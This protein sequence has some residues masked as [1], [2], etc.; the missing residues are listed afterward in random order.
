[1]FLF[2]NTYDDLG[3]KSI[4]LYAFEYNSAFTR[5]SNYPARLDRCRCARLQWSYSFCQLRHAQKVYITNQGCDVVSVI[6]P[7]TNLLMRYIPVGTAAGIE[8]PQSSSFARQFFL[9]CKFYW[10]LSPSKVQHR[11][12]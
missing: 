6:D 3:T 4:T 12:R 2:C 9:V 1:M 10:W 8:A 7:E 5:R 11:Y